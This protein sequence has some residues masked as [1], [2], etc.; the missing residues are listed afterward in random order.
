LASAIKLWAETGDEQAS[1]SHFQAAFRCLKSLAAKTRAQV[2]KSDE[3]SYSLDP[4]TRYRDFRA[5]CSGRSSSMP[6]FIG[7]PSTQ[8]QGHSMAE[9]QTEDTVATMKAVSTSDTIGGSNESCNDSKL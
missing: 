6:A 9:S 1:V 2:L 5:K 4:A 7:M 8:S 3:K